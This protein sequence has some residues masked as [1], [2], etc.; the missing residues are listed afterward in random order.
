MELGFV[1]GANVLAG[2]GAGAGSVQQRCRRRGVVVMAFGKKRAV[3][4][5]GAGQSAAGKEVIAEIAPPPQAKPEDRAPFWSGIPYG[6]VFFALSLGSLVF[7]LGKRAGS[8][9][10]PSTMPG[11]AVGTAGFDMSRFATPPTTGT[12]TASPGSSIDVKAVPSKHIFDS[13]AKDLLENRRKKYILVGG[14]G[15]VGKT[16]MSAALATK[17]ADSSQSTLIISTDPAHSLSDAFGID[18]SGGMPTPVLGIDNLY[19]QEI[20]PEDI[21]S[22]INLL[23]PDEK[24]AMMPGMMNE[25]GLDDLDGLFDQLPPGF[26]EA[27]ALVE[28]IKLIQGDPAYRKFDRIVF[29]TAPT[30]HTLRL[31]SLP[32]FMDSFLGKIISMKAK[33]G[34]MMSSMK[35]MFGGEGADGLDTRD[36]EE[37]KRNMQVVRDLFKDQQQTEFIVATIPNMMA[38]SESMRLIDELRKESIPVHYVFVNQIQQENDH[39]TFCSTRRKEQQANLGFV[40]K[41][42]TNMK[43]SKIQF[44]DR[45][46]RGPYALR[47]MGRQLFRDEEEAEEGQKEIK[48]DKTEA[49]GEVEEAKIEEKATVPTS[50]STASPSQERE[51]T[52]PENVSSSDN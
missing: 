7:S 9:A 14:K 41:T 5:Q 50:S 35:N 8:S 40:E 29:D 20:N 45:E 12:T 24:R 1:N 51:A 18:L 42:F 4:V 34:N 3:E 36:I 26:D 10:K 19:A 28:I 32:D 15:G 52:G 13:E 47:T 46:I 21:K 17:F 39:C 48:A 43:L 49:K 38:I 37:M 22:Q 6:K 2:G 31:L 44:F 16:S 25:M 33:F 27:V 30:G 23:S 11:P